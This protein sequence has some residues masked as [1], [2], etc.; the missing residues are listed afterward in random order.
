MC[1][2]WWVT[3]KW[4]TSLLSGVQM[5]ILEVNNWFNFKNPLQ[6]VNRNF[7]LERVLVFLRRVSMIQ[8]SRDVVILLHSRQS[9]EFIISQFLYKLK[10]TLKLFSFSN[11]GLLLHFNYVYVYIYIL[12]EAVFP[13]LT[14]WVHFL[15]SWLNNRTE[16]YLNK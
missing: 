6:A 13:L 14:S 11:K 16:K 5:S 3:Y 1:T 10:G 8:G 2:S 7:D 4:R 12:L 15:C 9:G